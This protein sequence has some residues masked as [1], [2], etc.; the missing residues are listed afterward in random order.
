[1]RHRLS[2]MAGALAFLLALAMLA[3]PAKG[4][5]PTVTV[6]GPL[7]GAVVEGSV[8]FQGTAED[9]DGDLKSVII[10]IEGVKAPQ[11]VNLPGASSN[12]TWEKLWNSWGAPDGLRRVSVVAE[13]KA[14]QS[15]GPV[16]FT[17][18]VD[19]F[20]EPR[21]ES[22]QVLFDEAGDGNYE[23]WNDLDAVP[24]TRL[25]IELRFSEEMDETAVRDSLNLTGGDAS[26]QLVG[27][28]AGKVFS[29]NVSYLEVNTNYTVS[30]DTTATDRAGNTLQASREL[31]FHTA[32]EATPGT[33]KPGGVLSL[34]FDPI[35]LWVGGGVGGGAVAG[36]VLWKRGFLSRLR[37]L[38]ERIPWPFRRGES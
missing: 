18:L 26:W 7:P 6:T 5:E 24:T 25:S 38:L 20:K 2:P 11:K 13:D 9:A 19:N 16:N 15:S 3:A 12:A 34:P 17:L 36:V 30:V 14:G 33:P 4:E 23:P 28:D 21:L 1:M 8:L 31:I 10:T 37:P 32:E 27:Q 22:F 35:W 29:A